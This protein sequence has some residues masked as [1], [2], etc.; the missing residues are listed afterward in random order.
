MA[1][2]DMT[3]EQFRNSPLASQM[4]GRATDYKTVLLDQIREADLPL[5]EREYV[6]H[7]KRK[8]RLTVLTMV[9]CFYYGKSRR[10]SNR[11]V[12]SLRR[13]LPPVSLRPKAMQWKMQQ[14]SV[15]GAFIQLHRVGLSGMRQAVCETPF[16][17][18]LLPL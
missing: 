15:A 5:P 10:A 11:S 7:D 18:S 12:Y 1:K 8:W 13:T 14:Q 6:F 9:Q 4:R 2:P 16:S 17:A 3:S